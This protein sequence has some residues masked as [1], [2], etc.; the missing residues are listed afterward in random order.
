MAFI[1]NKKTIEEK[2][3][4]EKIKGVSDVEIG[5]KFGVNYKFIENLITRHFGIT[6][7]NLKTSK[8]IKKLYPQDFSL[9]TT[10]LWSFK[11]RGNWATHS[12][13][14]RGNWSPYIPRNVIL[15]YTSP[16]DVVLD[17]FCGGGTT[18]IEAKLLGRR[19]IGIDINEKA[20]ELTKKNLS[21]EI[22]ELFPVYEPVIRVGDA[23]N[24]S[25]IK[26]ETIDLIC[27]H[28]P[29]ANIIHY[30]NNKEGDL[31]LLSLE[32]FLNE[33]K[34]V[35]E[36]S[37]RVLK[38]GKKC[39]ILIGDL[40]QKKHVI[41]LGFYLI[42]LFLK[43]GFRLKELI[44]KRQHNCKTTGFW[45]DRSIKYNFLLLAHEYLPIFEKP[46]KKQNTIK[47]PVNTYTVPHKN[48]FKFQYRKKI[49]SLET[50]TVWIFPRE[51]FEKLLNKNV[52]SRY[53]RN[54][55]YKIFFFSSFDETKQV[56]SKKWIKNVE[57]LYFKLPQFLN[58][59]LNERDILKYLNTIK[60]KV[61]AE[62]YNIKEGGYI[63]IETKD[64]KVNGYLFPVGKEIVKIIEEESSLWLKEIIIISPENKIIN[65]NKIIKNRT[66]NN[67]FDIVHHYLIIF[68]K[69]QK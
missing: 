56:L 67:S 12:N 3:I 46:E 19:C 39:A 14:Y 28:P 9:E 43:S 4:E 15:K 58:L 26:D 54:H 44:I 36:E 47:E 65:E 8:K 31:S 64:V 32:D 53:T 37:Y 52:I 27:S 45:Y 62:I 69:F 24:L 63:A 17:Y 66:G 51:N 10:T 35:A 2:I 61:L 48:N 20:V 6:L 59:K 25:F 13:E 23:R 57:L 1:K 33:M 68:E 50:S 40:R 38:P 21:F 60:A 42:E 22:K 49:C 16:E 11:N 34:K 18:V 29:Y 55:N 5:K 7:S 30:T 41:P